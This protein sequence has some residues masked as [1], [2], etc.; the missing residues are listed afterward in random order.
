[1]IP[2]P[3]RSTLFPY[4][5]LFRSEPREIAQD[6]QTDRDQHRPPREDAAVVGVIYLED[7]RRGVHRAE[8]QRDDL[9]PGAQSAA[10][11][12][13]GRWLDLLDPQVIGVGKVHEQPRVLARE[14]HDPVAVLVI[15]RVE[16]DRADVP[17]RQGE[18]V[19]AAPEELLQP[20]RGLRADEAAHRER[21]V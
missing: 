16:R 21:E 20:R 9:R 5:T 6:Q 15:E 14:M 10:A 13:G 12:R 1:M 2:R 17:P 8:R 4:T 18:R 7:L 19:A 3:P 11:P